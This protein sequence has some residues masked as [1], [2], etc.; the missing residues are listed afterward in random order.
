MIVTDRNRAAMTA[1]E[2][3][4]LADV[5]VGGFSD[6]LVP[7]LVARMLRAAHCREDREIVVFGVE[8][9]YLDLMMAAI[10]V[11]GPECRA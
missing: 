6:P 4:G 3:R 7:F 10:A 8:G 1:G 11:D 5:L 2:T 9:R